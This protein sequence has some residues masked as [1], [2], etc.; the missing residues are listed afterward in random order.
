M[1]ESAD[2]HRREAEECIAMA[3][4]SADLDRL[5]RP[6]RIH[7]GAFAQN[8]GWTSASTATAKDIRL[9]YGPGR[10]EFI[11]VQNLANEFGNIDV[12]RACASA[13][14]IEAVQAAR[15]LD[16]RLIRQ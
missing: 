13:R 9:E 15:R 7:A 3:L 11:L 8:F 12:C 5:P 16:M 4:Q 10:A 14:R 6:Q 1:M 2:D